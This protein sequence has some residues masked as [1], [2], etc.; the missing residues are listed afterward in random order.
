MQVKII[1]C[2]FLVHS[3]ALAQGVPMRPRVLFPDEGV[4]S[5]FWL[6]APE[7]VVVRVNDAA[8]IGPETEITPKQLAVRL[9]EI[10]GNIENSF[11]GDVEKGAVRFYYFANTLS[12]G[13]TVISTW[14]APGERYVVFLRRDGPVLRAMADVNM[15]VIRVRSGHH[16][17]LPPPPEGAP[18]GDLGPMIASLALTPAGDHDRGF[19]AS[20]PTT[21]GKLLE[22][23]T[24]GQL[25]KL[26]RIL[27]SQQDPE[28]HGWACIALSTDYS[29]RD[30]CLEDLTG[31][32][33]PE[34]R[35]IASRL[36]PEKQ[37][38][39]DR[40][41]RALRD[42]PLSLSLSGRVQ[43][44]FDD[45]E[46]FTFDREAAI[47]QQACETLRRIFALRQSANCASRLQG[48]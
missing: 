35:R 40:L 15:P 1:C 11:R 34:I 26:L 46:L 13:R 33:D 4:G 7:V 25:S 41:L 16:E 45:L 18:N 23:T 42:D 36:L 30:P 28:I 29:Y 14:Y 19:A 39:T 43:D 2:A 38:G 32:R 9:V 24:P 27:L 12:D 17:E 47:R 37:R 10:T 22:L 6:A 5:L 44:V 21:L 20:L 31:S 48:H 8:W 3:M